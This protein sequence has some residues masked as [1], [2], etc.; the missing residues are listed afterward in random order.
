LLCGAG[1]R[2]AAFGVGSVSHVGNTENP[3]WERGCSRWRSGLQHRSCLT[4]R[5]REQARS[6]I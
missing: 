6:H 1:A 2:F 4:H 5:Y 3:L